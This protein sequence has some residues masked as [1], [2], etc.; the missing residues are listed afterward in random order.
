M[1][2]SGTIIRR[3]RGSK[4]SKAAAV[5]DVEVEDD[6]VRIEALDNAPY[7]IVYDLLS[8]SRLGC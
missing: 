1:F 2:I 3:H 5:T 6:P 4:V 8:G 7:H